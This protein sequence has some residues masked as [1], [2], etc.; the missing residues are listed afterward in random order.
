MAKSAAYRWQRERKHGLLG[1]GK[2]KKRGK[3]ITNKQASY[4]GALQRQ[5][6]ETYTGNGMT[7]V[8]AAKAIDDA[9]RRLKGNDRASR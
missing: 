2:R 6:D 8:Q 1:E 9:K 7:V 5:L 3:G 4:L